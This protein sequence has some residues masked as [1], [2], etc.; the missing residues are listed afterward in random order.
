MR[1]WTYDF[2]RKS[3]SCVT[4]HRVQER[5]MGSSCGSVGRAVVSNTRGPRFEYSHRQI[6]NWTL[7]TVNCIE[8]TKLKKK[9]GREWPILCKKRKRHSV[10]DDKSVCVKCRGRE[11]LGTVCQRVCVWVKEKPRIWEQDDDERK[12]KRYNKKATLLRDNERGRIERGT[13]LNVR[14]KW[15]QKKLRKGTK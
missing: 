13:K 4:D 14:G 6:L 15:K 8:K 9:R 12:R 10:L 2:E 11:N 7:F 5:D 1:W 3:L